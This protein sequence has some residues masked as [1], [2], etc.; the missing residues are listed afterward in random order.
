MYSVPLSDGVS[1]IQVNGLIRAGGFKHRDNTRTELIMGR[2]GQIIPDDTVFFD[3]MDY[4]AFELPVGQRI[5]EADIYA[6]VNQ[7]ILMKNQTQSQS[8]A[9]YTGQIQNG[10]VVGRSTAV[11]QYV[12]KTVAQMEDSRAQENK[13]QMEARQKEE[14]IRREK[15]RE[16]D[17]KRR[18]EYETR[19]AI[20][21]NERKQNAKLTVSAMDYQM[22]GKHFQIMME[23][24]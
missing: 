23:L 21:G 8:K 13:A 7:Y 11:E 15:Q 2:I 3:S 5:T 6:A 20:R 12:E 18:I 24:I 1:E 14:A 4:I 10:E 22:Q 19:K 17:E 9:F 16:E